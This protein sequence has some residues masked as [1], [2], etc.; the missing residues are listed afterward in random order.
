MLVILTVCLCHVKSNDGALFH[1]PI[2]SHYE[3]YITLS[4]HELTNFIV[5]S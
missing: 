1:H 2:L 5:V 4:Y 3:I